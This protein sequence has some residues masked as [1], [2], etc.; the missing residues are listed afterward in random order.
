M[1]AAQALVGYTLR[2]RGGDPCQIVGS[3][4]PE[5]AEALLRVPVAVVMPI[6]NE[7]VGRVIEGLRVIYESVQRAG[8]LPGCHF[9]LLSDSTEPQLLD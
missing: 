6:C 9:F 1:G 4:A 8:Q 3:V 2:R 7:D 5:L